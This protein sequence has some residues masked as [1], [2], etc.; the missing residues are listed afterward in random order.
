MPPSPSKPQSTSQPESA[1]RFSRFIRLHWVVALGISAS[2]GLSIFVLL[3]IYV[4]VAG[5][6]MPGVPFLLMALLALPIILTYAER[7]AVVP[8]SGGPLDLAK[9]SGSVWLTYAVGW[10]LMGGY[11]ALVG[12][13][14]WGAALHLNVLTEHFF[15]LSLDLPLLATVVI[16]LAILSRSSGNRRNWKSLV[17]YIALAIIVLLLI[18]LRDLFNPAETEQSIRFLRST[19]L[20]VK[21]AALM[22]AGLWGIHFILNVR[23]EV[24]RPT[25]T[26]LPAMLL[27]LGLGA[28]AGA[29]AGLAITHYGA[30]PNT[31]TPLIEIAGEGQIIPRDL[32]VIGYAIF[33][34]LISL[35]TLGIAVGNNLDLLGAMTRHGFLPDKLQLAPRKYIASTT[36]LVIIAF[37]SILI[38][39]FVP[40]LV[41]VG[42]VALIFLWVAALV[43]LPDAFR[44]SPNLPEKRFPKLPF[45]PLFPWLT[46]AIGFFLLVNLE[47]THWWYTGAWIALGGLFY[48]IYARRRGL[49]A[50]QQEAVIGEAPSMLPQEGTEYVVLVAIINPKTAPVLLDAGARL[51]RA[52]NGKLLALNVLSLPEQIPV[53]LK[54][55]AAQKAWESLAETTQQAADEGEAARALVRLAPSALT[56]IME[57]AK[58]ERIDLLLIGWEGERLLNEAEREPILDPIIK[59][60]P[61]DVAILR[62]SLPDAVKRTLTVTSGGPH[63]PVALS[64]GQMLTAPSSEEGG[65]T[66]GGQILLETVVIEHLD[67]EREA[68]ANADFQTTLKAVKQ[69]SRIETRIVEA[70]S[71][72][73]G[74]LKEAQ[75]TD[76]LLL[77]ASKQ[78]FL[79]QSFF[80]GLPVEVAAAAD[81]A[82]MLVRKQ[83]A[84]ASYSMDRFWDTLE[85]I[86]PTLTME[87][88]AK[89][90]QIMSKSAQP[91]VDFFVLITLAAA[92]ASLGLLQNSGAVII[93]AMLVAPLMSPILAMAMSMVHGDL[94]LLLVAAEA[95]T[96]GIVMAI[97]VGVIITIISPIET[98]TP[99]IMS[100]TSP[101]LLDLLVALASGAAAGYAISRKEVAA[102]LPGVAIAAALVPPLCVVGYGIGT[103]QLVIAGDSLL[104]FTTNLI[105]I[106]LA[107]ALTFLALGF[108]PTRSERGELMRGLKVTLISMGAV[109]II[110]ALTTISAV[111]QLNREVRVEAIFKNEMVARAAK[112][113]EMTVEGNGRRGFV[114]Y[115]TV[116]TFEEEEFSPEQFV[117]L[118]KSL[119]EAVGG[120]VEVE[121]IVIPG[122]RGNL[123]GADRVRRLEILFKEAMAEQDLQ[124]QTMAV[125]EISGGFEIETI[126]IIFDGVQPSQEDLAVLQQYL[127]DEMG[128]PVAI[129]AVAVPGSQLSTEAP[130]AD[131]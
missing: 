84:S 59:R 55:Q 56:G 78:G 130:E 121:L 99:E 49:I 79:E 53:H 106:V 107:A 101:N 57:T 17:R 68:A 6:Q 93:G 120:P 110:L 30:L 98:A 97:M 86:M 22:M 26:L 87:R 88:Q 103:S 124:I 47:G 102:A 40:I 33:G 5:R 117:A 105:A 20:V 63:A 118:E 44:S 82:V 21:I 32:L 75:K 61:C 7:A 128:E 13:L 28:G 83:E 51:A 111:T 38:I 72:K 113:V 12:L 85:D 8:G 71:V 24:H 46:V 27:T 18:I 9:I 39:N 64:L 126:L 19:N 125:K 25:Q 10:L 60:A 36:P 45:H 104:L 108:T 14:A 81:K 35:A 3:G 100:R 76:L 4:Q 65:E 58:E 41:M 34:A 62:G 123:E 43:H 127:S 116:I 23:D 119:S 89:V 42:L 96:K 52:R 74:I 50:R 37:F 73:E 69:D 131:K 109:S 29:L 1:V 67:A 66:E 31:L 112:I 91:T 77:G 80:G 15:N 54:Q 94:R 115:S 16:G 11:A 122:A 2:V 70:D 129:H 90:Y 48:V 92:I 95:T 114:I